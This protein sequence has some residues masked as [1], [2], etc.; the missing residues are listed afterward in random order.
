MDLTILLVDVASANRDELKSFLQD[1]KFNV[2]T[3]A[4]GDSAIRCC[5]QMQPDLVLLYDSLPDIDSFE[6]CRQLKKDP[7]NQLTPVVLVRPSLDQ[8][9]T[10]RGREA[11]ATDLWAAPSSHWDMFGRI[12][13]LLRLQKYMEEQAKAVVFSL[14]LSL[15]SKRHL[16]NGHSELLAKY[17]MQLGESLCFEEEDLYELRVGSLLHDIGKIGM[18]ERIL[19]KPGPLNADETRIMREHP[20]IGER[21][22]APIKSLRSILPVIRHHHEKMDGSGY[23]DGLRGEAIPLKA[24]I[25]QI[26]DIYDA[27]TTPRAYRGALPPADAL[28]ILFNEAQ[29]GWLDASLVREFS[30]VCRPGESFPVRGRSMMGEENFPLYFPAEHFDFDLPGY[31]SGIPGDLCGENNSK[32]ADNS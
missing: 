30:R 17:A 10:Y 28:R 9:D 11:G 15:D 26:A 19:L 25:L 12:Q 13:T 3:A 5:L 29:N 7:F 24:R 20:I 4:D 18:P 16:R 1:Q 14:A 32:C 2:I 22:C 27:L 31:G 6:L 23:P 8:R 21:I